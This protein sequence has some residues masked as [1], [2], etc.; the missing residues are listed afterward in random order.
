MKYSFSIPFRIIITFFIFISVCLTVQG[1][2]LTFC[3]KF[4]DTNAK[5]IYAKA[6]WQ[7]WMPDY[8]NISVGNPFYLIDD[9]NDNCVNTFTIVNVNDN[10]KNLLITNTRTVLLQQNADWDKANIQITFP[11]LAAP[12]MKFCKFLLNGTQADYKTIDFSVTPIQCNF[13]TSVGN[14]Q[15]QNRSYK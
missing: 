8:G 10:S 5:D 2:N 6:N 4:N 11:Q 7:I 13:P 14:S 9:V 12:F 15:V 3:T 1:L